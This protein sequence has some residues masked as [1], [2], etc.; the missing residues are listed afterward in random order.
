MVQDLVRDD[1]T[2]MLYQSCQ[3]EPRAELDSVLFQHLT[4]ILEI[5]YKEN[6]GQ[7]RPAYR[8]PYLSHKRRD[9]RHSYYWEV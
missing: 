7:V 6:A 5:V 1:M 4:C 8:A 2:S 9:K 3:A